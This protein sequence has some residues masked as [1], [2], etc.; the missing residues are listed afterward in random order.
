MKIKNKKHSLNLVR[1]PVLSSSRT[2]VS[3]FRVRRVLVQVQIL[4]LQ[5]FRM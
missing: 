1:M 5:I 2:F 3:R 4:I